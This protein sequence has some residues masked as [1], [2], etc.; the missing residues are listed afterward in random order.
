MKTN[1]FAIAILFLI[2]LAISCSVNAQDE[3][4]EVPEPEVPTFVVTEF[5]SLQQDGLPFTSVIGASNFLNEF[6]DCYTIAGLSSARIFSWKS[7]CESVPSLI[8]VYP[9]NGGEPIMTVEVSGE[10]MPVDFDLSWITVEGQKWYHF[11]M[12]NGVSEGHTRDAFQ[13]WFN[14]ESATTHNEYIPGP[15]VD[16][17]PAPPTPN[18]I[19][20]DGSKIAMMLYGVTLFVDGLLPS[21]YRDAQTVSVNCDDVAMN[22]EWAVCYDHREVVSGVHIA[23]GHVFTIGTGLFADT[24]L[25][26][27]RLNGD[28]VAWFEGNDTFTNWTWDNV[29]ERYEQS[30]NISQFSAI[31]VDYLTEVMLTDGELISWFYNGNLIHTFEYEGIITMGASTGFVFYSLEYTD[32]CSFYHNTGEE[33]IYIG[34][35][36][37]ISNNDDVWSINVSE[38][39][40][41]VVISRSGYNTAYEDIIINK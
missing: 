26:K 30:R 9:A 28:K 20:V 35:F 29:R 8:Y 41:Q 11:V 6:P 24:N 1:I 5:D 40:T 23:S 32:L 19:A 33:I 27:I 13:I 18:A 4:P 34:E 16:Y 21:S 17:T 14:V 7:L 12:L 2:E 3:A 10:F 37:P 25:S 39:D 36:M 38:S 15:R 31:Q 22:K